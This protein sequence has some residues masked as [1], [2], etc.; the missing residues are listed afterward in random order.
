MEEILPR[1]YANE[2]GT[3]TLV[4]NGQVA[5][6]HHTEQVYYL[7]QVVLL[8]DRVR[9]LLHVWSQ[10]DKL[11]FVRLTCVFNSAKLRCHHVEVLCELCPRYQSV[12]L[13][14]V[15]PPVVLDIMMRLVGQFEGHLVHKILVVMLLQHR[16]PL[17]SLPKQI[18][19]I[20]KVRHHI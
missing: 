4:E 16:S 17:A 15:S 20:L 11:V 18:R 2:G 9:A 14:F 13:R 8:E 6:V 1:D 19:T 3:A 7:L 10:V 12:F 5:Q